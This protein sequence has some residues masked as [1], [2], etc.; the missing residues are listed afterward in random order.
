MLRQFPRQLSKRTY[1]T[2]KAVRGTSSLPLRIGL[3]PAD[4]IGN[5]VIPVPLSPFLIAVLLPLCWLLFT[6]LK[7]DAD[8]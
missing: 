7:Q 6:W 3:I 4:G 2:R 1:A 8:G 5:E